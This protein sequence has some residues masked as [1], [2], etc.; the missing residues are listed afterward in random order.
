MDRYLKSINRRGHKG[1]TQRSQRGR[2]QL[3]N[4]VNF[5]YSLRALRL[6]FFPS[7]PYFNLNCSFN[8]FF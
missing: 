8:I 2:I 7:I 4:S 1:N 6:N 5:A 3:I